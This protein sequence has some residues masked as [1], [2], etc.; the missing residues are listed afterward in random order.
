MNNVIKEKVIDEILKLLDKTVENIKEEER[1]DDYLNY[2][3]KIKDGLKDFNLIDLIVIKEYIK[4]SLDTIEAVE[5]EAVKD[6]EPVV[7]DEFTEDLKNSVDGDLPKTNIKEPEKDEEKEAEGVKEESQ[8]DAEVNPEEVSE[9]KV[10][11][12]AD[13]VIEKGNHLIAAI[14]NSIDTVPDLNTITELID[15]KLEIQD[16]IGELQVLKNNPEAQ[17]KLEIEVK[18]L[19]DK[20]NKFEERAMELINASVEETPETAVN[21]DVEP[22]VSDE[23]VEDIDEVDEEVEDV[24]DVE[25]PAEPVED[26]FDEELD[27]E[28]NLLAK[29]ADIK[30][31]VE[32]VIEKIDDIKEEITAEPVD[33]VDDV[34][35]P[36][37]DVEELEEDFSE[38]I[39]NL[40]EFNKISKEVAV[41]MD[42]EPMEMEEV[43]EEPFEEEDVEEEDEE[44]D[45]E[46][47]EE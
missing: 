36:V 30:E 35:E 17:E 37:E 23:K 45:K 42:E 1:P 3:V 43:E 14:E 29:L 32:E 9:E 4:D 41:D 46:K 11:D 15:I 47:E 28:I 22:I 34:E 31:D 26:E 33:D 27:E 44:E 19:K 13:E 25:E 6:V 12:T 38:D 16:K 7:A 40:S 10:V 18:I 21:S 39:D 8:E 20:L 5:K 2:I 24:E